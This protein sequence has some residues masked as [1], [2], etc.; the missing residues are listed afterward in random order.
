MKKLLICLYV[1]GVWSVF[2]NYPPSGAMHN[3]AVDFQGTFSV[4]NELA[5]DIQNISCSSGSDI[6][7]T[8]TIAAADIGTSG[9]TISSPGNYA[10][11]ENVTFNPVASGQAILI[12]ASGV[13]LDLGC[14]SLTQGNSQSGV[15]GVKVASSLN[16]VT[17]AHGRISNFTQ[18]G[19]E[20]SSN[21][22]NPNISGVILTNNLRGVYYNGSAGQPITQSNMSDIEIVQSTTAVDCNYVNYSM[23]SNIV[24]LNSSAAAFDVKNS[25]TNIFANV[26]VAGVRNSVDDAFGISLRSGANNT[27]KYSAIDSIQANTTNSSKQACGIF[28]AR[29]EYADSIENVAISNVIT[30][31]SAQPLGINLEVIS[32]YVLS[33]TFDI[34]YSLSGPFSGVS[35]SDDGRYIAVCSDSNNSTVIFEYTGSKVNYVTF[36]SGTPRAVAWSSDHSYLAVT[37]DNDLEVYSFNGISLSLVASQS[38]GQSIRTVDW[39]YDNRYIL[40]GGAPSAGIAVRVYSFNGSSLSLASNIAEV[41]A[42]VY[43]VQFA[44]DSY[45]FA[46]CGDSGSAY[47]YVYSFDGNSAV[48]LASTSI[49]GGTS[50]GDLDWSYDNRYIAV[51]QSQGLGGYVTVFEWHNSALVFL[52]SYNY[53]YVRSVSWS[54]TGKNLT[55][56]GNVG[57]PISN[58]FFDGQNLTLGNS[59]S[60][61]SGATFNVW[62][63]TGARVAIAADIFNVAQGYEFSSGHQAL[64][65]IVKNVRGTTAAGFSSIAISNGLGVNVSTEGNVALSNLVNFSDSPYMMTALERYQEFMLNLAIRNQFPN[66]YSNANFPPLV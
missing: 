60:L 39:S 30:T 57:T 43:K 27:I 9:Y 29:D 25:Y 4:L 24:A 54:P 63:P 34:S 36:L 21:V 41:T 55:V 38:H 50:W 16:N 11:I 13:N 1:S 22:T 31:S 28:I 7:S 12:N 48:L 44:H 3:V 42:G 8:V 18:A 49:G 62:S 35:W 52:T 5:Q 53:G 59:L 17:I 45:T 61:S 19:I 20:I 64:N 15:S 37:N 46:T 66:K 58:F 6:C 65:N 51:A 40:I 26:S 32:D 33:M 2:A 10:L 47:L 14:G 56:G 23:I